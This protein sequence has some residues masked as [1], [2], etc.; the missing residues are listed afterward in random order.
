MSLCDLGL[1]TVI[2]GAFGVFD[3]AAVVAV[4]GYSPE[5][6]GE[7]FELVVKLHRLCGD[8]GRCGRIV[9]VPDAVCW[10]EAPERLKVVAGQRRRWQRGGV[11]T[12][13]KHRDMFWRRRHAW[14]AWGALSQFAVLDILG[15]LAELAGLLLIPVL[16]AFGILSWNYAAAFFTISLAFG[17]LLSAGG[18]VLEEAIMRRY[19]RSRDLAW[20]AAGAL[21]ENFGYRQLNTLW[22]VQGLCDVLRGRNGWGAA[23]ARMGARADPPRSLRT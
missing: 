23:T 8:T 18:L 14:I 1:L 16:C 6:V 10:T 5:I 13:L 3:R 15:P 7:D 22:R 2:S 20:L 4:G 12:I 19:S 9:F 17:F 11:Q 21:L